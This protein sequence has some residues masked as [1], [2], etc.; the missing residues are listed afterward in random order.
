VHGEVFV[1]LEMVPHRFCSVICKRIIHAI[2]F[3]PRSATPAP[4]ANKA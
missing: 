3:I 4:M 1:D 2:V